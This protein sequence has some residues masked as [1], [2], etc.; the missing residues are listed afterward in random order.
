MKRL[1]A[2]IILCYQF[3]SYAQ[4]KSNIGFGGGIGYKCPIGEAGFLLEYKHRKIFDLYGGLSAAKFTG[5]GYVIGTE[6]YFMRKMVQPCIGIAYNYRYGGSFYMGETGIDRTDYK[7][8]R[9]ANLVSILG[10]R[11]LV[12][13]DDANTDGFMAFTPYVSYQYSLLTNKII[14]VSGDINEDRERK[15]NNRMGNGIGVGIK[16]LY[17]F[18]KRKK[19]DN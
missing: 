4:E 19:R 9:N 14:Y 5:L 2:F 10:I 18:E 16:A 6:I 7:V 15:I 1:I 3:S 8:D 13:F 12:L 11:M 17:F